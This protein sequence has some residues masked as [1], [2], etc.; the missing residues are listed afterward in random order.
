M[1]CPDCGS[2]CWRDEVDIGVGTMHGPWHC[3]NCGWKESHE[4]IEFIGQ[5]EEK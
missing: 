4:D 5:E 3:P 1:D 2:E